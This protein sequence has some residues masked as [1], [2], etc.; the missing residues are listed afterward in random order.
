MGE[1]DTHQSREHR[2]A[3]IGAA[4]RSLTPNAGV[5]PSLAASSTNTSR[6]H[7]S[8]GQDRWPSSGT[9]QENGDLGGAGGG[10]RH[11]W[12]GRRGEQGNPYDW[13]LADRF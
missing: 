1:Q 3:R 13:E 4:D 9:P 6:P 11:P 5:G 7:G 12:H 8:P 10:S 2:Q